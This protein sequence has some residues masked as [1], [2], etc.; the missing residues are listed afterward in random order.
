MVQRVAPSPQPLVETRATLPMRKPAGFTP[1]VQRWSAR[2][3]SDTSRLRVGYYGV[4]G[5]DEDTTL[6]A[7]FAAWRAEALDSAH[8]PE[9]HDRVRFVDRAGQVNH[10]LIGYWTDPLRFETWR[11][12]TW[13]AGFWAS[14]ERLTGPT[15]VWCEE[16]LVPLDRQETVY[17]EDFLGGVARCPT[18]SLEKTTESGYWGGMRDRIPAAA[19]DRLETS[20]QAPLEPTERATR[21]ARWRV[22]PPENLAV[23]R[24]GQSW[25]RCGEE[26]RAEYLTRLRPRMEQ[27]LRYL[28]DKPELSGCCSLRYMQH[29]DPAGQAAQETSVNGIFRSLA[30]LERWS[31]HHATH[32]AI[33]AEAFRQLN[34]YKERREFRTWHEVFVLSAQD[35]SL[36]YL[37][38][39]PL[40]GTLPYLDADRLE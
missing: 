28:E 32:K 14:P 36:S 7:P 2:F 24:S 18:A 6:R 13:N 4:Q 3:P 37:N 21:G 35:Q 19:H 38:C 8:A 29:L 11:D 15:G 27:G 9:A 40:T 39:H 23:I 1:A 17:F 34:T 16:L 31:E 5:A 30:D 10:M 26:Q 20:H 12:E 25:E 33:Y 22:R